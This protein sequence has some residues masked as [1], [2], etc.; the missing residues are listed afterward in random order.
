V[1]RGATG[2]WQGDRKQSTLWRI[3]PQTIG[4]MRDR[5]ESYTGHGAQKPVEAMARP[6]RNNSRAGELVYDPFLGSGTSIVAAEREGRIC[7]GLEID[8]VCCEMILRRWETECHGT[9]R[10]ASSQ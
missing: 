8:P 3:V 6:M 1:R 10:K 5:F 4:I 2:H 7:Y 9:A